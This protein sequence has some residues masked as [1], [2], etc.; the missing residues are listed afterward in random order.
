MSGL[1]AEGEEAPAPTPSSTRNPQRTVTGAENERKWVTFLAVGKDVW[2]PVEGLWRVSIGPSEWK[3]AQV[4]LSQTLH[5]RLASLWAELLE[6]GRIRL[7]SL[8]LGD[9]SCKGVHL[10][11]ELPEAPFRLPSLLPEVPPALYFEREIAEMYGVE[12]AG[13]PDTRPLLLHERHSAPPMASPSATSTGERAPFSFPMTE[14]EGV[15]EI[16]VGPVHAGV[17]EP[18]HFRFQVVGEKILNLEVRLG[19]THKGTERL[20]VGRD[21][22]RGVLLAESIS[23][24]M[25]VAG[26]VAYLEAVES[27]LGI[28][29]TDPISAG[30][31][32]LLEVERIAFLLGD[33]AGIALDVGYAAGAAQANVLR[34]Q[35]YSVMEWLTG[36]RLGRG[37]LSLGGW[38]RPLPAEAERPVRDSLRALGDHVASLHHHLVDRPSVVDRLRGTG[39]ITRDVATALGLVGPVARASGLDRD[40]RRDRPR[41]PYRETDVRVATRDTGDVEARLGVKV[42]EVV[43]AARLALAMLDGGALRPIRTG[44]AIS[45]SVPEGRRGLGLVESPRGEYLVAV[46]LDGEGRLARVHVRDPSFLN[47]PAIE[48]A[49]RGNIVPDFPLC[50]KSL[51]LSYSGFDR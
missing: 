8:W 13:S 19:Y 10:F 5:H 25:S 7:N 48:Y 29:V 47:W 37:T 15:Y 32:L 34:D 20:F 43:E 50:N 28:T 22:S 4:G 12:F 21:P 36:A 41:G 16:P 39:V 27:A 11:S 38:A 51:N 40:V 18:G 30:R 26:G 35:A 2:D 14:G 45:P 17:I 42:A 1:P 31:G 3:A 9:G 49:V 24:D 46:R 23:G 33:I 6:D 44:D